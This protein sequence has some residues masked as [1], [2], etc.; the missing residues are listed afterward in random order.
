MRGIRKAFPGVLALD[1]VDF[2]LRAGEIQSL[3]GENGAGKSTLIKI[4]TGVYQPDSGEI[5]LEGKPIQPRSPLEAQ[6]LG[7][8]TVY[9]EVNLA[10]NLSVAENLFL[11]R[12]PMRFGAIDWK[13][14]RDRSKAALSK[15][16]LDIDPRTTLGE[17]SIAVQQLVAI[18]RALDVQAKALVLDEPTSS[19]DRD[20]VARLFDILRK[21]RS[22]GLAIL[23]VSHFLDQIYDISD[24]IT[25]LRN[26]KLVGEYLVN[27][28]PR[29]SLV[30]KMLGREEGKVD[31]IAA[32]RATRESG[33]PVLAA[34]GV[35]TKT[36][37]PVGLTLREGETVGLAGLLGSGRTEIARM[38]FGL[39]YLSSGSMTLAG[40]PYRPGSPRAAIRRGVGMVP[41]DRKVEG[42]A[43]NLS[44][45]ENIVLALQARAG[46]LKRI[47]PARQREIADRYIKLLSIATPDSE[48]PV[49]ELSGGNQQKVVL[50]RWLASQPKLLLLD[51]P[52][53]GVDVGA[54]ADIERL[55]AELCSEG[56]AILLIA[57]ELEDVARESQRVV[58]LR[59][60][61]VVGEL[62]GDDLRVD[63]IMHLIAEAQPA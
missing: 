41:E 49:G 54:K 48:A 61:K 44:V 18:A 26:G 63:R 40:Q 56:M 31:E 5:I 39:D 60:R 25:V 32:G 6:R 58:V 23:F 53:R 38:L 11:G 43:P 10:P 37:G 24:R 34:E 19:L 1:G 15:V 3:M 30:A 27:D 8:S 35:A 59:D 36:T 17:C 16:G 47:S 62:V 29:L 4:L 22:D 7:I 45:R 42:I 9:Q 2:T 21:L 51:E 46:W 14:A 13:L 50:A 55:I 52:T 20:E 12:L 57:S 33:P 28:L